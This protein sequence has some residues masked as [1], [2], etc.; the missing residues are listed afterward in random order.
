[1]SKSQLKKQAARMFNIE[2]EAYQMNYDKR[3]EELA[4]QPRKP[5]NKSIDI[6]MAASIIS[7]MPTRG[8]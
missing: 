4:K 6:F 2:T 7:A 1:M 3:I 5:R 8:F